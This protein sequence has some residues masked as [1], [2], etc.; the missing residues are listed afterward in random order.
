M[1]LNI[2]LPERTIALFGTARFVGRTLAGAGIGVELFI[3][4]ED[5]RSVWLSYY[6]SRLDADEKVP[7]A[8]SSP[9]ANR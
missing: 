7:S 2:A 5:S 9:V 4:D 1:Q 8:D 6:H 3:I